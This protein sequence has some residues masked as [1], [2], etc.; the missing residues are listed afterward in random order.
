MPGTELSVSQLDDLGVGNSVDGRVIESAALGWTGTIQA[1][2]AC[3]ITL[4]FGVVVSHDWI[5]IPGWTNGTQVQL[6]VG[7]RKLWVATLANAI[8]PGIAVAFAV[9]FWNRPKPGFV[10]SYWVIYCA[11]TLVSAIFMWYVPYFLGTTEKTR[12]DYSRM[13]A[14][15][16][17]VLRPRKDN[18]RPNLLHL[19]FHVLFVMNFCLALLVRFRTA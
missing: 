17:Q 15:T 1:L 18:P 14:G 13:Y 16:R 5:D 8:F 12:R 4:Q 6:V 3:L 10:T 7:R 11:V 2:F 19:C 9:N